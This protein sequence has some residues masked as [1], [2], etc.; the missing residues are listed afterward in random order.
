MDPEVAVAR[1]IDDPGR[2][3]HLCIDADL[4]TA[5]NHGYPTEIIRPLLCHSDKRVAA[6]A[7]DVLWETTADSRPYIPEL[8]SFLSWDD[9][10]PVVAA[11][12]LIVRG[13]EHQS[14]VILKLLEHPSARVRSA[15]MKLLTRV[16][17]TQLSGFLESDAVRASVP[18]DHVEGLTV[19]ASGQM[20]TDAEI[21]TL[22]DSPSAVSR[23][24]GWIAAKRLEH[25]RPELLAKAEE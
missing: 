4:T 1:I 2:A 8:M 17:R 3:R 19:V 18:A 15:I 23:R 16:Q 7:L 21:L 20:A 10:G 6:I 14:V 12:Q 13:A 24:Y 25:E 9:D 22:I 11:A 5:F